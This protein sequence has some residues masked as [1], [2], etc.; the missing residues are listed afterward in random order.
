M[1]GERAKEMSQ[2]GRRKKE[3]R[4]RNEL[5]YSRLEGEGKKKISGSGRRIMAEVTEKRT[6][7]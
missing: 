5:Y 2:N 3:K 6:W 7:R 1:A 4:Q